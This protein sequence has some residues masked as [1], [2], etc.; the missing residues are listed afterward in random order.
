MTQT[1]FFV[2][3]KKGESEIIVKQ[4]RFIGFAE[5]LVSEKGLSEDQLEQT[6]QKRINEIRKKFHNARHVCFAYRIQK[7]G[8]ANQFLEKYSDDGEPI[9][10]GGFPILQLLQGHELENSIAVV[11][12][13]FG[14]IKLGPGGLARAY[15]MCARES[16]EMSGRLQILPQ[17]SITWE[18]DYDLMGPLE[19]WLKNRSGISIKNKIFAQKITI[20]FDVRAD[21]FS[22]YSVELADFLQIPIHYLE[23]KEM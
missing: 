22:E 13:Y 11:V 16:I 14:G 17:R 9:R 8:S 10:T 5:P 20:I 7:D 12:R 1:P 4:S 15:R 19:H 21:S 3:E 23:N 6:A 2:L 18:I